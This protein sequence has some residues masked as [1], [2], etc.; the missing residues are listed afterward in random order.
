ME[1]N[2][3]REGMKASLNAIKGILPDMAG[4]LPEEQKAMMIKMMD[5]MFSFME[6]NVG[7][8]LLT[9]MVGK[10]DMKDMQVLNAVESKPFFASYKK[11]N[12]SVAGDISTF[13]TKVMAGMMKK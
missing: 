4:N 11:A 1:I 8:I 3:T 12:L 2:G 10:V 6:K 9:S 13:M 7:T 5:T